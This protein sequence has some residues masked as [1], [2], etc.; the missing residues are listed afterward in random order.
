MQ[1]LLVKKIIAHE[2]N[3]VSFSPK[4]ISNNKWEIN[5]LIIH[6]TCMICDRILYFCRLFKKY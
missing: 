6:S 2:M 5:L 3:R 1:I 4:L